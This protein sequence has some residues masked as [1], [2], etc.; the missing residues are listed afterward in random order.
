MQKRPEVSDTG[1]LPEGWEAQVH[2][3]VWKSA[4]AILSEV[5]D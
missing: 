3:R 4:G 2:Q 5:D 1:L